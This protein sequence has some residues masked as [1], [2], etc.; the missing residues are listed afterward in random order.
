MAL[1]VGD[2]VVLVH[3]VAGRSPNGFCWT[4]VVEGETLEVHFIPRG[5][6]HKVVVPIDSTGKDLRGCGALKVMTPLAWVQ[7]SLPMGRG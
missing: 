5:S 6:Q 2:T 3:V 7:L 1:K 4:R